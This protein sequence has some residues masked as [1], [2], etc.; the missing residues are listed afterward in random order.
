D[1]RDDHL[2]A[3]LDNVWLDRISEA[4]GSNAKAV[5]TLAMALEL[6]R[7]LRSPQ[8][9][10]KLRARGLGTRGRASTL[11]ADLSA[12]YDGSTARLAASLAPTISPASKLTFRLRA[13]ADAQRVGSKGF[14]VKTVP[15]EWAVSAPSID[16][17]ALL[18]HMSVRGLKPVDVKASLDAAGS[19]TL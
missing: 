3:R 19:G 13:R 16:L 6:P 12:R 18:S 10:V 4:L 1:K 17:G 5:G 8:A 2:A 11:D 9:R 14:D 15:T 7:G